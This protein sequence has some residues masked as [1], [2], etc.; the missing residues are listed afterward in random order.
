MMGGMASVAINEPLSRYSCTVVFI[1][2]DGLLG[3]A[4]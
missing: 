4:W 1:H 2:C 3:A